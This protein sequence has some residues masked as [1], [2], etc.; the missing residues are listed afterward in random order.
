LLTI[1]P[2]MVVVNA[3]RIVITEAGRNILSCLGLG[4]R[5]EKIDSED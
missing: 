1:G 5:H 3:V 2:G 4:G